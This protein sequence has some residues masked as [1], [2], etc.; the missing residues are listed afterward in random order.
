MVLLNELMSISDLLRLSIGVIKLHNNPIMPIIHT[1]KYSVS[2]EK[3][4]PVI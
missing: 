2:N 4:Y 1:R 3:G